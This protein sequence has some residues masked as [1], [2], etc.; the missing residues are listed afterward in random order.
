MKG[1]KVMKKSFGLRCLVILMLVSLVFA[2]CGQTAGN[3]PQSDIPS[4][5]TSFA[6]QENSEE[7]EPVPNLPEITMN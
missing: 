5:S 7:T 4:E 6:E 1:E 3:A 2:G